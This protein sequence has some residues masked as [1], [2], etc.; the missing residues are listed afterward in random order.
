MIVRDYLIPAAVRAG[1]IEEGERIGMHTLR[2]SLCSFLIS[3]G[4]NPT[5]AQ[6]M[7]RHRNAHTTLQF[8]SHSVPTDLVQAQDCVLRE[9][10][11]VTERVQ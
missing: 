9:I 1:V 3:G 2:H 10:F 5:T 11:P 4:V 7:L 8:Y 6:R